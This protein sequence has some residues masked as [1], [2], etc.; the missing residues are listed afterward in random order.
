MTFF[1]APISYLRKFPLGV[2]RK[3]VQGEFRMIHLSFPFGTSVN[4]FIPQEF[5]SVHYAKVNDAIRF[6]K[7][8]GRCCT[9]SKT[10]VRS[11][12]RIIQIHPSD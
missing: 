6:I 12:F 1:R 9:L 11:A 10:D 3:K 2:I 8:L 5:C 4:D 7:R